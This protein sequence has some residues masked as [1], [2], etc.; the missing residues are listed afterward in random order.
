VAV[1]LLVLVSGAPNT[2][3]LFNRICIL[4]ILVCVAVCLLVLVSGAP[5]TYRN[6]I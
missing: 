2:A 3:A 6:V 1:C 5:Y 4:Q